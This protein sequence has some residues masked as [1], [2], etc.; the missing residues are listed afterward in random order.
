MSQV[1]TVGAQHFGIES[2]LLGFKNHMWCIECGDHSAP[3]ETR[4]WLQT[5]KKE[6]VFP[7]DIIPSWLSM[8]MYHLGDEQQNRWWP[9][10]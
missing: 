1:H 4:G 3:N 7:V 5:L 8:L 2:Y 6:G 10:L 9:Q